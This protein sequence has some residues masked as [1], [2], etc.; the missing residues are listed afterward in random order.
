MIRF[1][2]GGR[3]L[4]YWRE[5]AQRDTAVRAFQGLPNPGQGGVA[6]V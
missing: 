1:L 4:G 6:G 5:V 3:S 2:L